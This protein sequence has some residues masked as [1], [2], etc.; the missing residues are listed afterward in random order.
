MRRMPCHAPAH[1]ARGY[2]GTPAGRAPPPPY[3]LLRPS[4][5]PSPVAPTVVWRA[6]AS[7]VR[8]M[9]DDMEDPSRWR[10]RDRS[11]PF[12]VLAIPRGTG[13]PFAGTDALDSGSEGE[14]PFPA[15]PSM[16][17]TK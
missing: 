12:T 13:A 5:A 15:P 17:L 9:R 14:Y 16:P 1:G 2:V 6:T 10:T 11:P 7:A 4:C 3:V 8:R